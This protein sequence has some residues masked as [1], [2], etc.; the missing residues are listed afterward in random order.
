LDLT[1]RS[2]SR[3]AIIRLTHLYIMSAVDTIVESVVL[4]GEH[5]C[6]VTTHRLASSGDAR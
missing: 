3:K 6:T 5:Y 2:N 1:I 4:T